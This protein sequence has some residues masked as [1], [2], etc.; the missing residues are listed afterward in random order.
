[1]TLTELDWILRKAPPPPLE[2]DLDLDKG[3]GCP[4]TVN[5][6][7]L[8]SISCTDMASAEFLAKVW[9]ADRSKK[10]SLMTTPCSVTELIAKGIRRILY[11]ITL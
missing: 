1:M 6:P 10:K 8:T 9:N 3:Q 2:C 7:L 5:Y 11:A 4:R